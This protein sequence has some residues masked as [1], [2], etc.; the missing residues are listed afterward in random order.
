MIS[1]STAKLIKTL[2]WTN[3][4][5]VFFFNCSNL[6]FKYELYIFFKPSQKLHSQYCY[7]T[8]VHV[9]APCMTKSMYDVCLKLLQ[10]LHMVLLRGFTYLVHRGGGSRGTRG[11]GGRSMA[12]RFFRNRK[13]SRAEREIY[14][15]C[16]P[17]LRICG[18]SAVSGT[19]FHC[20]S[21]LSK[22]CNQFLTL[23]AIFS[24][25]FRRHLFK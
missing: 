16:P 13:V 23:F 15:C 4:K 20:V 18:P 9:F 2:F 22:K 10:M 12:S 11:P 1:F 24:R 17:P 25:F 8:I 3:N 5:F 19:D 14:Y 6:I 21:S 7:H